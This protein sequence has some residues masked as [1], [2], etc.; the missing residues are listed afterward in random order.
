V[1]RDIHREYWD[2]INDI[3]TPQESDPNA[4]ASMKRFWKFIKHKA[5]DFDGV[6]PL[7]VD[8]KLVSDP[9]LKAEALN[10]QFQ[11]V[12]TRETDLHPTP[13]SLQ[14]PSMDKIM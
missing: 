6:A 8:G 9:K 1:Q 10:S 5:T 14:L 4:F 12:F 3:V 7:K 13:T 2:Y 11:S